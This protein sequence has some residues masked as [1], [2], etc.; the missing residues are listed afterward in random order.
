MNLSIPESDLLK[1]DLCLLGVIVV[2]ILL[3]LLAF[4]LTDGRIYCMIPLLRQCSPTCKWVVQQ[5][6][7]D[8]DDEDFLVFRGVMDQYVMGVRRPNRQL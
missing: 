2:F 5:D 6:K 4:L 3:T 1:A 7:L 8:N